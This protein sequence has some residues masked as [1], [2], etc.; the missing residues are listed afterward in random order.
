MAGAPTHPGNVSGKNMGRDIAKKK[1]SPE[2]KP[3]KKTSNKKRALPLPASSNAPP[4]KKPA[5]LPLKDILQQACLENKEKGWRA[6]EQG[7]ESKNGRRKELREAF[8]RDLCELRGFRSFRSRGENTHHDRGSNGKFQKRETDKD[9]LSLKY[10]SYSWGVGKNYANEIA[11]EMKTNDCESGATTTAATPVT[12]GAAGGTQDDAAGQVSHSAESAETQ[13][14]GKNSNTAVGTTDGETNNANAAIPVPTTQQQSQQV[15]QIAVA[16]ISPQDA[17]ETV[18]LF[19]HAHASKYKKGWRS[20]Q[21]GR[22][23]DKRKGKNFQQ[24]FLRDLIALRG[25]RPEGVLH[26]DRKDGPNSVSYLTF[27]WGVSRSYAN[28]LLTKRV[29]ETGTDASVTLSMLLDK[30]APKKPK[31]LKHLPKTLKDLLAEGCALNKEKG[32]RARELGFE[33]KKGRLGE[34]RNA[35]ILDLTELRGFQSAKA[36]GDMKYNARGSNGQFQK[37]KDGKKIDPF[38]I[39]YLNYAWGVGRNYSNSVMSNPTPKKEKDVVE[40][41]DSFNV[42]AEASVTKAKGEHV[43]VALPNNA[44]DQAW[45]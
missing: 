10:L 32:W 19:Q 33:T 36:P 14:S 12:Q 44:K 28:T 20:W 26:S 24:A 37:V 7:F 29:G 35:F 30:K 25:S 21:K 45:L 15:L 2:K 9:P 8:F 34:F 42:L 22:D 39:S 40:R 5:A 16:T 17:S 38:S 1:K 6:R 23:P 43:E 4:Q 31:T 27:S 3:A 13:T 18:K 11:K 41:D